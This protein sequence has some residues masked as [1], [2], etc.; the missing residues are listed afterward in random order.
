M[1]KVILY[2]CMSE[3]QFVATKDYSVSWLDKYNS[4]QDLIDANDYGKF[5]QNIGTVIMGNTTYKQVRFEL[6]P[7]VWAYEGFKTYVYTDEAINENGIESTTLNP[8]DLI[9]KI[10]SE[11]DKDIFL[12]GGP[13]TI[14]L[15]DEQFLIDEYQIFTAPEKLND[16][17]KLDIDFSKLKMVSK[18]NVGPLVK[19]VYSKL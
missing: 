16:G 17:I 2:I 18:T 19:R 6:M 12:V 4:N 11:S 15:F 13:F 1:S 9:N 14:K 3:D 8:I 5:I 7:D 10:K